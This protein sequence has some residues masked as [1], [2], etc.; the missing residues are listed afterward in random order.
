MGIEQTMGI[1][2]W[3]AAGATALVL[4]ACWT[5]PAAVA[6][7]AA[8]MKAEEALMSATPQGPSDRPWEQRL[9]SGTV[10]T[11]KY[12]KTGP[13]QVCF[14]NASVSN[15][16]RVEGWTTMQAAAEKMKADVKSIQ[17]ADGQGKDDK[18]ISDIRAFVNS[19]KCDVLIVS[20]NTSDALTPVV[21][22]ACR[23]LPVITFDRGVNTKCPVTAVHSIGGYAYGIA[24]ARFVLDSMPKGGKLL[25]LKTAPGIDV[26]ETRSNAAMQ[27]F[28][29]AGVTPVGTEYT[30]A[31]NAKD[32]GRGQRLSEPPRPYRCRL[33]RFRR[34]V[35][36]R[37]RSLRGCRT[38]LSGDHRR[39]PERLPA[40]MAEGRV[41]GHRADLSRL[42]V[43]H[44]PDR[45]RRRPERR[46]GARPRMGAAAA[47]HHQGGARQ[48]YRSEDAAP[49]SM[50]PA[51]AAICPAIPEKWGG[52]K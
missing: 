3:H 17:Y 8:A 48:L 31:D 25:V 16:W 43:A 21:E 20:P 42:S 32:Q 40:E 10:D 29:D 41:Q 47:G 4:I 50:R 30:G 28:K 38:A 37:R 11:A 19:G 15:P 5:P 34:D 39:G 46:S 2:H 1:R 9:N 45:R 44:R 52:K 51:A 33:G 12:K 14:S 49:V 27:V 24:G 23:K 7:E 26:F 35:G 6:D 13:Y 18:Q 36:G 22:E